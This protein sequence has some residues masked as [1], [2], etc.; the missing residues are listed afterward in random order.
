VSSAPITTTNPLGSTTFIPAP[1][2]QAPQVITQPS[3]S[4]CNIGDEQIYVPTGA[5]PANYGCNTS[6]ASSS[7]PSSSSPAPS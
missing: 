6:P 4:Y 3:G 1:I 2:V 7:S 5:S